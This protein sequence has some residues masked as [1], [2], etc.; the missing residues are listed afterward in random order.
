MPPDVKRIKVAQERRSEWW[1]RAV[2]EELSR[3]AA[4]AHP[5]NATQA[6]GCVRARAIELFTWSRPSLHPLPHAKML[7]SRALEVYAV[8]ESSRRAG[9]STPRPSSPALTATEASQVPCDTYGH[10]GL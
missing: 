5:T 7:C 8:S 10:A 1:K 9:E 4:V 3:F 2:I 6:P